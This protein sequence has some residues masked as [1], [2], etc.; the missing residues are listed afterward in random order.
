MERRI[1]GLVVNPGQYSTREMLEHQLPKDMLQ[2]LDEVRVFAIP[3]MEGAGMMF[4]ICA[5]SSHVKRSNSIKALLSFPLHCIHE[6]SCTSL[7]HHPFSPH[8][9]FVHSNPRRAHCCLTCYRATPQHLMPLWS[10]C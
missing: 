5:R 9:S 6:G 1:A 4:C 3:S 7:Y 2:M 8:D 10:S